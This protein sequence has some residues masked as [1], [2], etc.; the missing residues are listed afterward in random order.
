M[1]LK[2][3]NTVKL[4]Y[5]ELVGTRQMCSLYLLFIITVRKARNMTMIKPNATH[6]FVNYNQD[7][8]TTVFVITEYDCTLYQELMA[9]T[10]LG[11]IY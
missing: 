2:T 9:I 3:F 1:L 5:N 4:G 11:I 7:F 6:S 8:V 10:N